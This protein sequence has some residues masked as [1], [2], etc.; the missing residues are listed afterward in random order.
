M[1][2]IRQLREELS[3]KDADYASMQTVHQ[4][5]IEQLQIA[6]EEA[7]HQASHPTSAPQPRALAHLGP[8]LEVELERSLHQDELMKLQIDYENLQTGMEK[9]VASLKEKQRRIDHR[10]PEL[11]QELANTK[12]SLRSVSITE[13]HST[14]INLT[15]DPDPPRALIAATSHPRQSAYTELKRQPEDRLSLRDF[16]RCRVFE[17]L[18]G[19]KEE[20]Y[21]TQDK[22]KGLKESERKADAE[23][24]RLRRQVDS[25]EREAQASLASATS[26][27]TV[28]TSRNEG[29]QSELTTLRLRFDEVKGMEA[30]GDDIKWKMET[31]AKKHDDACKELMITKA[32]LR[33]LE[34]EKRDTHADH[35][36]RQ[37]Q[38][39]LLQ[40]DKMYLSKEVAR[41]EDKVTE[42]S[43]ELQEKRM[44][45]TKA[46]AARDE[47]IEKMQ[48]MDQERREQ[49]E[50]Q[51]ARELNMIKERAEAEREQVRSNLRE[52][53]EREGLSLRDARDMAVAE[54]EKAN[55][56]L[57]ETKLQQ[58]Y[59]MQA[60]RDMESK[61][62]NQVV[63]ARS[64]LKMKMFELDRS[65]LAYEDAMDTVRQL[66][67]ENEAF[68]KKVEMLKEEYYKV[69]GQ[70]A[71]QTSS[72]EAKCIEMQRRLDHYD[73]LERELDAAIA[74]AP[75][76]ES[77]EAVAVL[78]SGLPTD[79]ARRIRQSIALARQVS[80][81][82]REVQRLKDALADKESE[83]EFVR[84][85]A[86]NARNRIL[87][88]KKGP[89]YLIQLLEQKD[90]ELQAAHVRASHATGRLADVEAARDEARRGLQVARQDLKALLGGQSEIGMIK[91]ALERQNG[92][93]QPG[94]PLADVTKQL[95]NARA[96][97]N[98]ENEP[99]P[100][101]RGGASISRGGG[102]SWASK[103]A[104]QRGGLA[105]A[106]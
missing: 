34:E 96:E 102:S 50:D 18:K 53:Y 16:V 23:A 13:V 88:V 41:L 104:S 37:K 68:R 6:I 86:E 28:L 29:L 47:M 48:R 31:L 11:E 21:E 100:A 73:R 69:D 43:H 64:Q 92:T 80:D 30:A 74:Q 71:K 3:Q 59:T 52:L 98:V 10:V 95:A 49:T 76:Q 87:Q 46:K 12:D 36:E 62:S 90:Q 42:V 55:Q 99:V 44:K 66:K 27:I 2:L 67:L 39:E 106:L 45:L 24:T 4:G 103:L 93:R 15:V 84:L 60:H 14:T 94:K 1:A 57:N 7:N 40:V 78:G 54:A 79:A 35:I 26:D 17:E 65:N 63:E 81:S 70:A 25:L 32:A 58:D 19:Y 5:E 9:E 72:L 8:C 77:A 20:L 91:N 97:A 83:L 85:E 101:H 105:Q 51:V 56:R 89:D 61:L 82:H 38:V 33:A 75:D 22:F